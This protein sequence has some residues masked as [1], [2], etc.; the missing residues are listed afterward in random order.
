MKQRALPERLLATHYNFLRK[1]REWK[2]E[3]K[4]LS[5]VRELQFHKCFKQTSV[6]LGKSL[7]QSL[8][9][10]EF[11]KANLIPLIQ[12]GSVFDLLSKRLA[13]NFL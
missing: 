6:T 4:I 8:Y 2:K 1:G 12:Q 3:N 10:S 9:Q 7:C 13:F 5:L 11:Q